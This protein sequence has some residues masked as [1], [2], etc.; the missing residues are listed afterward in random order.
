MTINVKRV[1]LILGIIYVLI[2]IAGFMP[3]LIQPPKAGEPALSIA[4]LHGDLFGLFPVN[5][6]HTL[7]HLA[8]GIWGMIAARS[9]GASVMYSRT[10]AVIFGVLTIMGLI[11][12]LKTVYGLIP[13]Y[14]HDLWLHALTAIVAA[15]FGFYIRERAEV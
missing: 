4:S 6:L 1:A 15:Y 9:V 14:S 13:L 11:P 2:G 5:V 7:I 12:G 3:A 8:V 10:L